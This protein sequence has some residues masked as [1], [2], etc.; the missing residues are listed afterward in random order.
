MRKGRQPLH[1]L[2]KPPVL[3]LV[4]L[5]SWTANHPVFANLA[6]DEQRQLAALLARCMGGGGEAQGTETQAS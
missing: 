6:E 3:H 2:W 4:R 1:P 5:V